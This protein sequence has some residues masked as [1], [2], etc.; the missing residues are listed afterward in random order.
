MIVKSLSTVL[1][2]GRKQLL[3][4]G[5]SLAALLSLLRLLQFKFL[6]IDHSME[7]YIGAIALVFTCLGI[8]L[9]LKLARPETKVVIVEKEAAYKP[10]AINT[11]GSAAEKLG[12]SRREL[13]VMEQM[14]L[15]L[16]NQE[17][18]DKLFLS[19]NTVKTHVSKLFEKLDVKRRTQAIEKA[20][21]IGL[22]S[23]H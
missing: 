20:R 9:A 19:Q 11:D 10:S 1:S 6:I 13:E 15:G 2:P 12:I 14:A 22:I 4:Y 17:I 5:I 8:W 3:L 21:A 7:L 23:S 18:A 16:S